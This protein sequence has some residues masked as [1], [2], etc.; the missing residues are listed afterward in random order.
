[1][2]VCLGVKMGRWEPGVGYGYAFAAEE[3]YGGVE[4][5]TT[6]NFVRICVLSHP[7]YLLVITP[8]KLGNPGSGASCSGPTDLALFA[9]KWT[10]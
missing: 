2:N 6:E 5:D 3:T 8:R 9:V 7:D 10:E 1:M 4:T